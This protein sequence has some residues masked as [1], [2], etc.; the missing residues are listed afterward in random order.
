MSRQR[1]S[2]ARPLPV[3]LGLA[4]LLL[5]AGMF[6]FG[7]AH[8]LVLARASI[9]RIL[10]DG[11]LQHRA[12]TALPRVDLRTGVV[13]DDGSRTCRLVHEGV[14]YGGRLAE[15]DGGSWSLELDSLSPFGGI[16]ILR[17]SRPVEPSRVAWKASL[18][19]AGMLG[20]AA[21]RSE[22]VSLEMD[23]VLLGLWQWAEVVG[24]DFERHRHLRS[25]PVAVLSC[26]GS[27][28]WSIDAHWTPEGPDGQVE[29]AHERLTSLVSLIH[30]TDLPDSLRT[31]SLSELVDA[32]AFIRLRVWE[33]LF[34][35]GGRA[36]PH[37]IPQAGSGRLYPVLS[38][39]GRSSVDS[40]VTPDVTEIL[41]RDPR[42]KGHYLQARERAE[43]LLVDR[44]VWSTRVLSLT[45]GLAPHV[46]R[47]R[48][49]MLRLTS[50]GS[51]PVRTSVREWE[52]EVRSQLQRF[53][54]LTNGT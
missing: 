23:G 37:L 2:G 26:T 12:G 21:A 43:K 15:V 7:P 1:T 40:T 42:W 54:H 13:S 20:V 10:I 53:Q 6:L 3:L 29:A 8:A 27:T 38:A 35:D 52:E 49:A 28:P 36:V 14:A 17:F 44:S 19:M 34:L 24:E 51:V 25:G 16:R 31:D 18:D 41:L 32:A 46:A 22:L 45:Q 48:D 30:A 33:E 5:G 50:L 11:S 9:G 4:A 39:E 47:D